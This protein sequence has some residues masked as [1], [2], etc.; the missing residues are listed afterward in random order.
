MKNFKWMMGLALL[1]SVVVE[2]T[3]AQVTNEVIELDA[4]AVVG[5]ATDLTGVAGAASEGHVGQL[6]LNMRPTLRTAEVLEVVPGFIATQHSGTGKANQYFLRGFNLDHGTDFSVKVDGMP[7]NLPTHGHGQGY[8]DVNGIIP[9]LVETVDYNK[10][11]YSAK[12]GDFSSAGSAHMRLFDRLD[13]GLIKFGI[14]QDSFLRSLFADSVEAGEGDLLW[15]FEALHYDG[16]W[17]NP[18]NFMKYNGLLRY[19][20]G[21]DVN[22]YRL[23]AMGY[24]SEWDSTDQIP[25]RAVENGTIDRLDRINDSTG[26]NTERYS[27]QGETWTESDA[28]LTRAGAYAAYYRLDLW[29]DFT[30]FL[31]DP[32]NGD[33]FQ[34]A[35]ERFIVGTELTHEWSTEAG[36]LPMDHVVGIQ[37]RHDHIAEVGL[38]NTI[39]RRIIGTVRRDQV[40]ETSL[41]IFYENTTYWT[42]R[43]RTVAGLRADAFRFDVDGSN[44]ANS[45]TENDQRISPKLS[46]IYGPVNQT[47]FYAS[48][49]FGFHSNDARGTTDPTDP[50]DPLVQSFGSE[51]GLRTSIIPGLN[52]SLALWYLTLD[53]EL[54]FVGDAGNTE[55]SGESRRFGLE[56]AN[57]YQVND[58]LTLDLDLAWVEADL[59][60][61]ADDEIPGAIPFVA[62]AGATVSLENGWFGSLRLRHF[63]AFPLVEDGSVEADASS[64]FNL[65]LGRT[66]ADRGL[67]L[68]LDV[69]NLFDAEENDITYYYESQLAGEPAGVEGVH[70]HPMEPRTLRLYATQRF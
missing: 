17:R 24:S 37:L 10:G 23:S 27:L 29:S 58:W 12:T 41:G 53:E 14:G 5:R 61:E 67:T 20:R 13:E 62:A 9:E 7:L 33:Q 38:Y 3:G 57:Y 31:N 45:G 47:E 56:W 25:E 28:G 35:D 66:F 51:I 4:I 54:L 69:M 52:S 21:D 8:L 49:G 55:A 16:P 30:Y 32:V 44:P 6:E 70:I 63:D 34:Q 65:Q 2:Q 42:D 39:D 15:A 64:V 26:G 36:D 18:E 50:A 40:D 59:V 43:L 19:T 68:H 60:D 11:P 22:G 48:A 1:S 46:V